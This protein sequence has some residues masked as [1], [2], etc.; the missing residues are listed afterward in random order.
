MI[1]VVK[2]VRAVFILKVRSLM[3]INKNNK[4]HMQIDVPNGI[5]QDVE[6]NRL[7]IEINALAIFK[8][9]EEIAI[10]KQ[11]RQQDWT[12]FGGT[13]SHECQYLIVNAPAT[14]P[15]DHSPTLRNFF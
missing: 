3:P 12:H 10:A 4:K 2:M 15:A 6:T 1:I 8:N 14:H 7:N 11:T 5:I 9:A 13:H